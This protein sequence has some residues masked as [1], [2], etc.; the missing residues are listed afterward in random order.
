MCTHGLCEGV[1]CDHS[2][3]KT[4]LQQ[5]LIMGH[6]THVVLCVFEKHSRQSTMHWESFVW[7]EHALG[8]LLMLCWCEFVECAC[9]L[10]V[11]MCNK[12]ETTTMYACRST[13]A[14][15]SNCVVPNQ[16]CG[17]SQSQPIQMS[18]CSYSMCYPTTVC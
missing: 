5:A 18:V 7:G 3:G 6:H 14:C 9:W 15:K 1:N 4:C 10:L 16:D 2:V 11:F 8:R 17:I 13:P 12:Q